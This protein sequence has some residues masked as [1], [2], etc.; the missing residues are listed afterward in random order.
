MELQKIKLENIRS[1]LNEEI[2]FI[3]GSTLLAGDVGSGKSTILLAIDFALF[4][5]TK[6]VL[7]GSSLLRN[8]KNNGSVELHFKVD[9]KNIIIKRNL[10]R[11]L[12]AVSQDTGYIIINEKKEELSPVELKQTILDLLNY[13]K[14]LLTK[15]KSLIYRYTIYTPQEEMKRILTEDKEIRLDTLRRV[16]NIDKYKTVKENSKIF[17]AKIKEKT[18]E[19]EGMISDLEHIKKDKN[20]KEKDL[21]NIQSKINK[22]LPDLNNIK[23]EILDK[24]NQIKN[25]EKNIS[26]LNNL[27]RK[28]DVNKANL[29]NKSEQLKELVLPKMVSL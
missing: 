18:K 11:I 17:T 28:L 24:E 16:F 22:L 9:H 6:G 23:K 20:E 5:I 4:G 14:E 13:P 1:Y 29:S 12:N 8:G 10:K 27:K 2:N 21:I 15:S 25:V 19:F 26:E 7:S 3:Q